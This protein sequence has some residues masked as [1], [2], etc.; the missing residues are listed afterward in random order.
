MQ[1][2]YQRPSLIPYFFAEEDARRG[3]RRHGHFL[4][5][6][7]WP[8]WWHSTSGGVPG[9]FHT[10]THRIPHSASRCMCFPLPFTEEEKEAQACYGICPK[11]VKLL[12][13][14]S[15]LLFQAGLA[16]EPMLPPSYLE[17]QLAVGSPNPQSCDLYMNVYKIHT[18][19]VS[20]TA[21]RHNEPILGSCLRHHCG[22]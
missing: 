1:G 16:Q 15:R 8:F 20:Q 17:L 10:P 21:C 11:L 13:G 18:F 4:V 5:R 14:R 6:R 22:T 3:C 12:L 2:L 19:S 9:P 7:W